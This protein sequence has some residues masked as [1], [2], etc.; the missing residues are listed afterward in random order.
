MFVQSLKM[1]YS[2]EFFL[3]FFSDM[4]ISCE[5]LIFLLRRPTHTQF[6]KT[7][8]MDTKSWQSSIYSTICTKIQRKV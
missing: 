8:T 5:R 2:Q 3:E 1:I 6:W 7:N 4:S